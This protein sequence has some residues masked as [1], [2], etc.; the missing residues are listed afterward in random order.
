MNDNFDRE[1]QFV[2]G[3][4]RRQGQDWAIYANHLIFHAANTIET[5]VNKKHTK[6]GITQRGIALLHLLVQN[7]GLVTQVTER[8]YV[9]EVGRVVLEG[10]IKEIATNEIVRK[11]FLGGKI[12]VE[13][14]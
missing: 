1:V 13:R 3:E 11:A 9:L 12:Q 10:N 8:C 2:K 4:L 7:A 6:Y 5:Y 14:E